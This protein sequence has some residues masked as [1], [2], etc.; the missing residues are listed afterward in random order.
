M[1][2]I[3]SLLN[4]LKQEINETLFFFL[5]TD[6]TTYGFITKG[7]EEAFEKQ[8]CN[9]PDQFLPYR[10]I[11][12]PL[13][14]KGIKLKNGLPY[15][16]GCEQPF[17]HPVFKDLIY[18]D[19]VKYLATEAEAYWLLDIIGSI[20]NKIKEHGFATIKLKV[21]R[22]G[23]GQTKALFTA[24]DGNDNIFYRQTIEYTDF[25]LD[26]IK[27]FYTDDI[28]LLPSEY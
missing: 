26:E 21:Y 17:K 18:T 4:N 25:P 6:I 9:I 1:N 3:A 28:L 22:L 20:L 8:N 16:T 15:F 27:L 23:N 24:D 2:K 13:S 14:E 19:G 7:T 12:Q 10:H 5:K 11:K